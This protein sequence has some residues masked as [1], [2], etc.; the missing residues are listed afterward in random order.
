MQGQTIENYQIYILLLIYTVHIF[1]MKMNLTFEVAIKR[2]VANLLEVHE[3]NRLAADD[4]HHFHNNLDTRNISIELLNKIEYQQEGDVFI[5]NMDYLPNFKDNH[6]K[7]TF[8]AK[9][10]N[11]VKYRMKPIQKIRILEERFA[12]PENKKLMARARFKRA[13]IKILT[14][15]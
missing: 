6:S 7:G 8:M 2:W 10:N 3:L 11:Q 9:Q 5:F 4:I 12:T 14:K 13:V 15:L 1:I